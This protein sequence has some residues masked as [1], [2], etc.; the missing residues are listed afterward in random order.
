MKPSYQRCL[1]GGIILSVFLLTGA[2]A[3]QSVEVDAI[4][5][6]ELNAYAPDN[7]LTPG[8]EET[9][10]VQIGNEGDLQRGSATDRQL[11]TTARDVAVKL[12]AGGTPLT[13]ETGEQTIGDLPETRTAEPEFDITVP[14]TASPGSY[15]L[16]VNLRYAYT[17]K[18]RN[19]PNTPAQSSESSRSVT[20]T[21]TV[22]VT[23]D[24]RFNI[25]EINSGLRV[26][27]EGEITGEIENVGGKK[28]NSVQ[29]KFAPNSES[30]VALQEQVAVDDIPPGESTQ[31]AIP[32]EVTSGAEAVTREFDLP[33]SFRDEDGIR[34]SDDDPS[35]RVDIGEQRNTFL[36]EPVDPTIEA[37]STRTLDLRVT[38]NLGE[39]VTDIEGKFFA[40]D[41]LD[42][43]NDE[44]FTTSL[45]PN[46]TTTVT[47]DL[48][49]ASGATIKNYP[50]SVDFRYVDSEG[51]SKLTDSYR[52]AISV[53]EPTD[54]GGG[55]P[56]G[57]L[58]IG[59]VVVGGV[60]GV[61][62]RRTGGDLGELR[63]R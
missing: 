51:D 14:D 29:I 50:A 20:R 34:Q 46:E 49:A 37:G 44:T 10:T 4:G 40:D 57:P 3:A 7:E 56:V 15:T 30:V 45:E 21:I 22:R 17:S 23:N 11:V 43:S 53:T 2:A 41:P 38:N 13:V 54:D 26:G 27:E 1:L 61:L 6:P 9:L 60:G 5:S 35:F 59:L 32:V 52:V 31:F 16:D 36:I 25:D 24:A 58:V 47:V 55:L 28:A 62:W 33:V 18:V 8:S 19:G 42:S 63:D 12:N 48:S 39:T